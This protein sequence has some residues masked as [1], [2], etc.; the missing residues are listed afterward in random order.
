[1]VTTCSA[2]S[3]ACTPNAFSDDKES[4]RE[5]SP[6]IVSSSRQW[7][8]ARRASSDAD[9]AD[10]T[11][12]LSLPTQ[13]HRRPSRNF[14]AATAFF[15]P[16]DEHFL[17]AS[18]KAPYHNIVVHHPLLLEDDFS[19]SNLGVAF[20]HFIIDVAR[21]PWFKVSYRAATILYSLQ[22]GFFI[23]IERSLHKSLIAVGSRNATCPSTSLVLPRIITSLAKF[24]GIPTQPTKTLLPT[25]VI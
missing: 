19:L 25:K 8:T 21:L 12:P 20:K 9:F 18:D 7:H 3:G 4:S 16:P 22:F 14:H 23:S 13:S 5:P 10:T 1:M 2:C 24:H 6:P 15:V 17:S 11:A